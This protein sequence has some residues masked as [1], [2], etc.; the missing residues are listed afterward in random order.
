MEVAI[1]DSLRSIPTGTR[2]S[3][4]QGLASNGS[5]GPVAIDS[6]PAE[7]LCAD[8]VM[9]AAKNDVID[10]PRKSLKDLPECV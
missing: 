5:G 2:N 9:N 7:Q 4:P 3:R 1:R 10:E 8:L 6:A